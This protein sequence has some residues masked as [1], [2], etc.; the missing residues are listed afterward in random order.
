MNHFFSYEYLQ[1]IYNQLKQADPQTI[2]LDAFM[3][4]VVYTHHRN[5]VQNA[6]VVEYIQSIAKAHATDIVQG[7][8]VGQLWKYFDAVEDALAVEQYDDAQR[9]LFELV[10]ALYTGLYMDDIGYDV[11]LEDT[12]RQISNVIDKTW[13]PMIPFV[14]D[15]QQNL[16]VQDNSMVSVLVAGVLDCGHVSLEQATASAPH[17]LQIAM[18]T[19]ERVAMNSIWELAQ[20]DFYQDTESRLENISTPQRHNTFSQTDSTED[21]M[22][23]QSVVDEIQEDLDDT[24][25]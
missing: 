25:K 10:S 19:G 6:T 4:S 3:T 24:P 20:S 5:F 8:E 9:S 12:V 1:A 2:Q 13:M 16:H 7:L 23:I 18:Q 15:M 14:E 21:A 17:W 11:Y 22:D